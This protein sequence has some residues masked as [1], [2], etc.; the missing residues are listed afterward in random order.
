MQ[1]RRYKDIIAVKLT[2]EESLGQQKS[3]PTLTAFHARNLE[4]AEI[5]EEAFAEMKVINLNSSAA[6][7]ID[8]FQDA[9]AGEQLQ[10]WQEDTEFHGR[11]GDLKFG[12]RSVTINVTQICNLR[13]TYCAAGGDGT[14]G[15]PVTK[16]SIEKTL[17]QLKFFIEKLKDGQKF[18]IS[19][20]GGEPLLYPEAVQ[21][22]CQYVTD[23]KKTK[24]FVPVFS[25]IT[26]ATL[27]TEQVA[28]ALKPYNLHVTVS[29]DGEAK[30]NDIMRPTKNNQ[31]STELTLQG[32]QELKKIHTNLGSLGVSAVVNKQNMNI[33]ETYKYFQSLGFDWYEFNYDYS[34]K[35]DAANDNYIQQMQ[36]LAAYAYQQG[37]KK[38]NS[39]QEAEAELRRIKSF[40]LYFKLLD[41]QQRI[42][43]HCGAGKSYF[44]IDARNQLYT[45]PWVVNEKSEQVGQGEQLDHV[46]LAKYQKPLVELN[47]CQT[48]WARYLCGGGCMYIHREHTGDK[49]KKDYLFCKRIRGLILT[50]IMYYKISRE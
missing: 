32:L 13:C 4:V 41:D 29:M 2:P 36:E 28:Q 43:N 9:E 38:N 44:M 50:T 26:N 27:V 37:L 23:L 18:T 30:T 1:M 34:D 16:I 3:T 5:S 14:Y 48:C 11:T 42:L 25:L 21:N 10:N 45:C 24:N 8:Q 12:I 7:D 31:S 19:F 15:D 33:V 46:A 35:S 47:N 6:P 20:V 39:R 49:H 22:I 40:D 17:P